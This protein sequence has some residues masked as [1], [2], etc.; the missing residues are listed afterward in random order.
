M[1]NCICRALKYCQPEEFKTSFTLETDVERAARILSESFQHRALILGRLPYSSYC[2]LGQFNVMNAIGSHSHLCVYF[3]LRRTLLFRALSTSG[4]G[5]Y[6]CTDCVDKLQQ[7]LSIDRWSCPPSGPSFNT[8][9]HLSETPPMFSATA[10]LRMSRTCLATGSA[11]LAIDT[12]IIYRV[13]S[14][15]AP[16]RSSKATTD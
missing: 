11:L 5:M 2:T 6:L 9:R 8:K 10:I 4:W 12:P 3:I 14:K 13:Q 16:F 7:L 1:L 15:C